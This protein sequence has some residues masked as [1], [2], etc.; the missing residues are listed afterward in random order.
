MQQTLK[1]N[2]TKR[3]AKPLQSGTL[4]LGKLYDDRGNLMNPSFAVKNGVR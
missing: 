2:V 1:A 4:L 3:K